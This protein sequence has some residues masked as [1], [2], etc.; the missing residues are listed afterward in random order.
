M[1]RDKS[2]LT[3]PKAILLSSIIISIAIL[4]HGGVIKVGSK[5]AA[6]TQA[7]TAPQPTAQ[8]AA[9]AQQP[10][11]QPTVTLDQVKKAFDGSLVKFG[12][13]KSK[14]IAVEIADPSC[15]FCQVAAGKNSDLNKQMGSR[16]TLVSEGGTYVA[17]VSEI[18][19]LVDGGKASFA[20]VYFP[21]HGNGEMGTKAL[22]CAFE[23]GKFWEA[24][25]LLMSSKGYDLLN[26]QVKNDK[27]KSQDMADFLSSAVDPGVMK[28]CLD[29]G[30][31]DSRLKDDMALAQGLG[32]SGTPGFFL[33]ATPFSGAYS[34]KD[35]ES[36][37]KSV[38]GN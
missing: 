20:W 2:F 24:H 14:L 12:D 5:T 13:T 27:S 31:Y 22:Y 6:V 35:M 18:K 8:A 21:G 7:N 19:K 29:G 26:N 11:Q 32:V 38:L 25:D 23:K 17:P 37:A 1:N 3:T 33:N 9:P 34:Y 15:P 16:F 28:Q 10:P 4:M 36:A 30:K